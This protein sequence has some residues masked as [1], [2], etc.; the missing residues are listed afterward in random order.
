MSACRLGAAC[1]QRKVTCRRYSEPVRY[2]PILALCTVVATS[3]APRLPLVQV[4][5]FK[6]ERVELRSLTLP[7]LSNPA[8]ATLGVSLRVYNPNPYAVKLARASGRF[9]LEDTDVGAV[10]LPN[11]DLP[12]RGE[13]RQEAVVTLPVNLSNLATFVRVGRGEAVPYRIEGRFVVDAGLLGQPNFGPYVVAQGVLRQP[14]IL[15]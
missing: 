15:P 5:E 7:T 3:C 8:V 2:W 1:R 13:G 10:D 6:V 14:R 12:A 9:L 11:I 4:P